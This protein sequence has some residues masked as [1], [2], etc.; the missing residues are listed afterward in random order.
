MCCR[1]IIRSVLGGMVLILL[2]VSCANKQKLRELES[3][4]LGVDVCMSNYVAP[5]SVRDSLLEQASQDRIAVVDIQG[6]V[7]IMDA[8]KDEETGEIVITD[9]LKALVV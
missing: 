8:V 9:R 1:G 7:L 4:E 6:E 2:C 5:V 3:R